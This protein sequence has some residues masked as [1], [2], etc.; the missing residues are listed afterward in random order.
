M[1]QSSEI[2]VAVTEIPSIENGFLLTFDGNLDS[3]NVQKVSQQFDDL[4]QSSSIHLIADFQKL[5]YINSTGL[6]ILLQV[7]KRVKDQSSSFSLCHIAS[8]IQEIID[9][10]GVTPLLDIYPTREEAITRVT[11]SLQ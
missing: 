8:T 7:S 4:L 9:L 2:E 3:L 1:T 10:V 5:R 11:R 6:G